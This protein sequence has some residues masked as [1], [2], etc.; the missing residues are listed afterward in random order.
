MSCQFER[1]L[2]NE[3]IRFHGHSCPGLAIG[4]RAAEAALNEMAGTAQT[5]LVCVAE[6]DMCGVDGIQFLTGCTYGKGN[7]IHRDYGKMAF[8][9]YN[10]KS[11]KGIRLVFRSEARADLDGEMS[12]LMAKSA[13]QTI[14][15]EEQERLLQLRQEIEER[16][17]A[18]PIEEVFTVQQ[19]NRG[20]PRPAKV[21]ASLVC[22]ECG[23]N[24]M[25]SRTRR[26]SGRTLCIPCF[27]K[28]EQKV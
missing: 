6:T 9:F 17:M 26:F 1:H 14:T 3:T 19:L 16:L 23:E 7:F 25:E 11:G 15:G 27:A 22:Q 18:L 12:A 10:R 8:S 21:L 2:I 20:V 13:E 4:I 5:D 24:T 28:V